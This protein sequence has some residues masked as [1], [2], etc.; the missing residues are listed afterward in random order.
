MDKG[1]EWYFFKLMSGG[2]GTC[3]TKDD[4]TSF[5][6]ALGVI[7]EQSI[8]LERLVAVFED[9]DS[10]HT[11]RMS[12]SD[13]V[14]FANVFRRSFLALHTLLEEL[15]KVSSVVPRLEQQLCEEESWR[16]RIVEWN[17]EV[18][19]IDEQIVW[20]D[21]EK[22]DL[23]ERVYNLERMRL[24]RV[25]LK[26]QICVCRSDCERELDLSVKTVASPDEGDLFQ[27][28]AEKENVAKI[29][30]REVS[31]FRLRSNP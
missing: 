6:G 4:I 18:A 15:E 5:L 3:V 20:I 13:F 12:F 31:A 9:C 16:S 23:L 21:R 1:L 11:G 2:H 10:S 27:L 29:L 8:L 22:Q 26:A 28:A 24:E 30:D 17:A 7:G 14:T 19:A 25:A